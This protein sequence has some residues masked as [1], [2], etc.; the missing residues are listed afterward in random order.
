MFEEEVEPDGNVSRLQS[1]W[2]RKWQNW[3]DRSAP[4]TTARWAFAAVIM[5]LYCVRV[6]LING[7][8]QCPGR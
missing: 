2:S 5:L 8:R 1:A 4:H 3:L 7:E 6:Y